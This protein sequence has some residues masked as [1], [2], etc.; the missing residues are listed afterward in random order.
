M[1][2]IKHILYVIIILI[3]NLGFFNVYASENVDYNTKLYLNGNKVGSESAVIKYDNTDY[4]SIRDFFESLGAKVNYDEE[5]RDVYIAYLNDVLHLKTIGENY[6]SINR[7]NNP[8]GISFT[9]VNSGFQLN[10][11]GGTGVYQIINEKIYIPKY[12]FTWVLRN[13]GYRLENMGVENDK[14]FNIISITLNDFKDYH[15]GESLVENQTAYAIDFDIINKKVYCIYPLSDGSFMAIY[16]NKTMKIE[17]MILI[18]QY[19]RKFML[20]NS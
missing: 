8:A 12:T 6:L 16:V 7:I 3:T 14:K 1:C 10:D 15:I 13:I 4:F 20:K 2:K 17:D 18:D 5:T 9:L 19:G 11:M